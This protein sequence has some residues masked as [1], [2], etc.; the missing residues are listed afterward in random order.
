MIQLILMVTPENGGLDD[1]MINVLLAFGNLNKAE[2]NSKTC[3][4]DEG[5]DIVEMID[6]HNRKE[7]VIFKNDTIFYIIYCKCMRKI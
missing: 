3:I 5:I 6:K 7:G 4:L 2:Y 1:T